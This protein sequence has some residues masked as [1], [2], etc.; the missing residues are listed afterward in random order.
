MIYAMSDIHGCYRQYMKMLEMIEF[1]DDDLL[2]VLGD[3]VDRGPE[4]M[5]V[6]MDMSMRANVIPILGNHDFIAHK[7]LG[8]LLLELNEENLRKHF[9]GDIENFYLDFAAWQSMGGDT[10]ANG[11]GKLSMDEREA[12]I[13][14]LSEFSLYEQI[15]VGGQKFILSHIGIP[16]GATPNNMNKFDAYDFVGPDINVDYSRVYFDDILLVTGHLPTASISKD[17]QGRVYRNNNH[18]AIDIG[19]PFGFGMGCVCLDTSEE[20]YV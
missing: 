15:T 14:Y 10:T 1:T 17:Y 18:V 2:Y 19:A 3:V 12:I 9:G 5:A 11:F 8:Q 6:L 20:F 16:D 7:I 13:E 4:P